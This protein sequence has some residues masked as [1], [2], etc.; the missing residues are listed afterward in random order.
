MNVTLGARACTEEVALQRIYPKLKQE[1]W[2]INAS[3]NGYGYEKRQSS[4]C[5]PT[6]AFL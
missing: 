5:Q 3:F 6:H 4:R 2:A 1:I